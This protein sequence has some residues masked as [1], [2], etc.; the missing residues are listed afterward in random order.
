MRHA[1]LTLAFLLGAHGAAAQTLTPGERAALVASLTAT[2]EQLLTLTDRLTPEQWTFKPA[3]D[4]WSVGEVAEHLLLSERGITQII[5]GPLMQ[6]PRGDSTIESKA[7]DITAVMLDR[8]RTF[9]APAQAQPQGQHSTP[10][11]FRDAW[12]PERQATIEL[13]ESEVKLHDYALQNPTAGVI[14]GHDWLVFLV[15][16][17]QR[18]LLQMEEVMRHPDFPPA[19]SSSN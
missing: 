4:R 10:A 17:N 6:N 12:T 1:A 8:S 13:V 9:N 14:D 16:H 2:H 11:T 19:E 18:H 5:E 3:P 7:A 15:T